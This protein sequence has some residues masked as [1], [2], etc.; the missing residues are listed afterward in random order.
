[1]IH[2]IESLHK[3]GKVTR[4]GDCII[5]N[6]A[7]AGKGYPLVADDRE[8]YVHRL[9]KLLEGSPVGKGFQ[10][11]HNCGNKSCINP[12]HIRQATQ[13]ENEK[14]KIIHGTYNHGKPGVTHCG[15]WI[16][17]RVKQCRMAAGHEG[18]CKETV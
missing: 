3:T 10:A 6:G 11:A 5:W 14:D 9:V 17:V 1:M 18:I 13:S 15:K 2:T 4:E 7:K 8:R 16:E 12:D